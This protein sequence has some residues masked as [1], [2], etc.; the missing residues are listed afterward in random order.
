MNGFVLFGCKFL[1]GVGG[2]SLARSDS[3]TIISVP[4]SLGH[5]HTHTNTHTLTSAHIYTHTQTTH[6]H[7][8]TH[9]HTH[10]NIRHTR[11]CF[12]RLVQCKNSL[13]WWRRVDGFVLFTGGRLLKPY[14]V[15]SFATI[16]F[17]TITNHFRKKASPVLAAPVHVF[18]VAAH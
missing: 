9:T 5:Q 17:L 11:H 6:W 2:V 13:L 16:D 18:T 12:A 8:H 7:T 4:H 14:D 15:H 1:S 3:V 10:T